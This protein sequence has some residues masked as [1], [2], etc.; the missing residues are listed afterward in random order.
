METRVEG[1][2]STSEWHPI[3]AIA[4]VAGLLILVLAAATA[5]WRPVSDFTGFYVGAKSVGTSDLYSYER[6]TEIAK[7]IN[8]GRTAAYVRLPF[9]AV[10]LYPLGRLP[11]R[12]AFVGWSVIAVL[13]LVGF[14]T[15]SPSR[16]SAAAALATSIPL[17][18]AIAIGQDVPILLCLFAAS[19]RLLQARR[20]F[21]S[22]LVMAV[23]L[24]LKPHIFG[25]L[26][27]IAWIKRLRRFAQGVFCGVLILLGI[28]FAVAG[29]HWISS[30]L[31]M[32][33]MNE[34]NI[35]VDSRRSLAGLFHGVPFASVWIAFASTAVLAGL[36]W[37]AKR[38]SV[39]A[40]IALAL[41]AGVAVGIH[42][43]LSDCAYII[44]L[45]GCVAVG[46]S[47]DRA[48]ALNIGFGISSRL[49]AS[50]MPVKP[51]A[52]ALQLTMVSLMIR[53][54]GKPHAPFTATPEVSATNE[55]DRGDLHLRP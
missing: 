40:G 25:L 16:L 42:T 46:G 18:F 23:C 14:V 5:P 9:Y 33:R 51:L 35:P 4:V 32:T 50:P 48:V 37:A 43:Y 20:E 10:A 53:A 1:G 55:P 31:S 41:F 19:M 7:S 30:Y 21:S 6:A 11:Y 17:W 8:E 52:F 54:I 27:V 38:L 24:M 47:I 29:P 44:P 28:S 36:V 26:L 49:I 2:P 34:S 13:A 39:P 3:T 45:A 22:G 12:S 15:L